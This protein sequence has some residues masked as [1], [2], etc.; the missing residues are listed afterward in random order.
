MASKPTPDRTVTPPHPPHKCNV[1]RVGHHGRELQAMKKLRKN[2]FSR[3]LH[4]S[5]EMGER[6]C[7]IGIGLLGAFLLMP[8]LV[9]IAAGWIGIS[10]A[11]TARSYATGAAEYARWQKIAVL[12]L[13][14]YAY[15][16]D[17]KLYEDFQDHIKIPIGDRI[18]REALSTYPPNIKLAMAGFLQGQ[19]HPDDIQGEIKLFRQFFWWGP[20][21]KAIHNWEAAD[22]EIK[23]LVRLA[24]AFHAHFSDHRASIRER[25]IF[26]KAVRKIDQEITKNVNQF[27]LNMGDASRR[28]T[29]LMIWSLAISTTLFWGFGIRF[30]VRF[31]Q[32]QFSLHQQLAFS[33]ERFRDYSDVAS[34]WYW[35]STSTGKVTYLSKRFSQLLDIAPGTLPERDL[36]SIIQEGAY[37]SIQRDDCLERISKRETFRHLSL[38][39]ETGNGARHYFEIS[40][41][42]I[43]DAN[44]EFIGYRGV[45]TDTT[46]QVE[47]LQLLVEAKNQ[48]ETANKAKSEF[49]TNMSHE[50]RTPLN[51]ILGFSEL[52]G[53][54]MLGDRS[55][56]KYCDYAND[57]HASGTH[58]LSIIDDILDL[59]KV[60]AGKAELKESIVS[61]RTLFDKAALL[62][63]SLPA[64]KDLSLKISCPAPMG[65]LRIDEQKIVQALVNTL[66]NACKFTPPGGTVELS[67]APGNGDIYVLSVRDTGI[68][69]SPENI[70]KVLSPF[71]QVESV[72]TRQHHGTG[73]GLPIANS[74]VRLHGG[75]LKLSSELGVGTTISIILPGARIVPLRPTYKTQMSLAI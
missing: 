35:E 57:I 36:E 21:S 15:T 27:T 26:L 51:A 38:K 31:I 29:T 14:R 46:M 53:R 39:I 25:D 58:L 23:K 48:A 33:E 24:A 45:G 22:A 37:D 74:L 47:S 44:G 3:L 10:L 50:L 75:E 65:Y 30:A 73:L 41:K 8:L 64:S 63:G 68:G 7:P 72:F 6:G 49:L 66:S 17:K 19:N 42:P 4:L 11:G 60:E 43:H 54:K 18:A 20:F 56:D 69:I 55:I 9:S 13:Y 52:I 2:F 40:G 12:D 16:G 71:G 67:A 32:R 70:A 5:K 59:A 61:V 1:A 28:S 62:L 34:D